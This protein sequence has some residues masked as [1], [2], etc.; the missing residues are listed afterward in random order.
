MI[1]VTSIFVTTATKTATKKIAIFSR[2]N[3]GF[4]ATKQPSREKL[5][6]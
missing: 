2:K 1:N 4:T 3:F 5:I 6:K